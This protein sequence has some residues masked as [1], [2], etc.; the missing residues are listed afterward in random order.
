MIFAPVS[1]APSISRSIRFTM[2]TAPGMWPFSLHVFANVHQ[3]GIFLSH[4]WPLYMGKLVSFTRVLA[5]DTSFRNWESDCLDGSLE[6]SCSDTILGC[7]FAFKSI[8]PSEA[9]GTHFD[10]QGQRSSYTPSISSFTKDPR[11][12]V[13]SSVL[14][15]TIHRVPAEY[16]RILVFLP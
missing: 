9:H 10:T 16:L 15:T 13:L 12:P 6:N 8:P 7:A 11:F 1:E 2:C 3:S 5:Y 14:R 4:H